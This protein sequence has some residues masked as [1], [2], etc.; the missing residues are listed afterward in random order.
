VVPDEIREWIGVKLT[1]CH[2]GLA[3]PRL[4]DLRMVS[5]GVYNPEG[6][7]TAAYRWTSEQAVLL[8]RRDVSSMTVALR[9][10][11]ASTDRPVVATIRGSRTTAR[12]TLDS[13]DWSFATVDVVEGP[14]AWLRRGH[15]VTIDV[16]PWFVPAALSAQ[17][18]D[19]RRH[20]LQLKVVDLR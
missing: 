14:L 15:I 10:P 16:T 8:L 17:S 1:A 6:E 9:R 12:V 2:A 19:L 13:G 18:E 20:G 4:R 11:D 3:P 5:W 7:G